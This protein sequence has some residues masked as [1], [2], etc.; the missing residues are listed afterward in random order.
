MKRFTI[1]AATHPHTTLVNVKKINGDF[2]GLWLSETFTRLNLI[3]RFTYSSWANEFF[4][5]IRYLLRDLL[6]AHTVQ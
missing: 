6:R 1:V 5:S 3:A 4:F 2:I